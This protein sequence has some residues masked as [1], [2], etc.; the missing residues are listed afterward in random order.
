M[1]SR[2]RTKGEFDVSKELLAITQ[3][4]I[5]L[6][7]LTVEKKI[8]QEVNDNSSPWKT[9]PFKDSVVHKPTGDNEVTCKQKNVVN[10][11]AKEGA[12]RCVFQ[13]LKW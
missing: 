2:K 10:N 8:D 9:A 4:L 12:V 11:E 5:T 13:I 3:A 1:T 7:T 6:S